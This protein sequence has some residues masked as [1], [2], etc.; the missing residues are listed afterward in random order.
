M[1]SG[2]T[3]LEILRATDDR[4]DERTDGQTDGKSDI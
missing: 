1:I 2:C 4:M 3:V